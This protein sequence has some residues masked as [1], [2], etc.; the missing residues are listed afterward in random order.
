LN[1]LKKIVLVLTISL[2]SVGSFAQ[3]DL[4][5]K[6]IVGEKNTIVKIEE[7]KG[8]YIGIVVSSDNPKA[9]IGKIFV[10]E[11]KDIKGIW[12]GKVYSAKRKEWYDAEFTR[13]G[14]IL[15]VDISVGF[16][17]KTLEWVAQ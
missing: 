11:L 17:S 4:T 9:E 16:F 7:H 5:G 3:S 12:K 13:K 1:Y 15:L 2:F 8:I 10:K 14:N 6:Y